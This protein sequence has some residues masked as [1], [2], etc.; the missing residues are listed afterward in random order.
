MKKIYWLIISLL[1]LLPIGVEA[2]KDVYLFHDY[3]CMHCKAE[4]EYLNSVK[5]EYDLDLHLYEIGDRTASY[6]NDNVD[7]FKKISDKLGINKSNKFPFTIIGD[8]YYIGFDDSTE[9]SM[10]NL[11]KEFD[12]SINVFEKVVNDEDVSDIN[13][14]YGEFNEIKIFGHTININKMPL[15]IIATVIGF[16]DGFNPCAMWVLIFLITML[17]NMK[18]KK[19]M[20]TLGITFLVTS[21]FVYLL[22]MLAWLTL[23]GSL[24]TITWFRLGIALV[25]LI[26]G[27]VNLNSFRKSLKKDDGCEVVDEKKRKKIITRIKKIVTEKSFILALIGVM[28]LA[29]SVNVIELACSAGLPMAFT[30]ILAINTLSTFEYMINILIYIF[31]FLIDDIIVFVIAMLTL[32]VTGISTKYTKYSHL[33]GGI[34]MVIIAVLMVFKPEWLMFNI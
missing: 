7:L 5:D 21:A 3:T 10:D 29:I 23:I 14:K 32:N 25:A 13:M 19:R 31:F 2:K 24:S 6:Y 27:L 34:I 16:I 11:L 26:G 33:V 12:N 1:I 4:I 20:W 9:K 8:R 22:I 18:N 15:P 30:Q 28:A 17:M